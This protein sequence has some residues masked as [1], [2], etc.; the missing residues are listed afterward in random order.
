MQPVENR[1]AAAAAR[2]AL[3][4]VLWVC[5][6]GA[7]FANVEIQIE[8]ASGWAANLPTWRIE[9]SWLN[10]FWG[11][12]T[13]TGYHVW[14]FSFMALMFH[15]P[16]L[17]TGSFSLRLEARILGCILVFWIVEDFLWFALNPAFGLQ[18]FNPQDVPWH[19]H[20]FLGIPLD[21]FL[22][23]AAGFLLLAWS[24]GRNGPSRVR[25]TEP[26]E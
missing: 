21:Y 6:L 11:D 20:W 19:R 9:N 13:I 2:H 10:V 7:F 3:L 1:T 17:M 26:C 22:S 16:L 18:R 5:L 23:L 25:S 12:K 24:F 14:V 8:G 4:L 15:L